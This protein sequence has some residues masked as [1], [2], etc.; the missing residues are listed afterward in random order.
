MVAFYAIKNHLF[1]NISRTVW[2]ILLIFHQNVSNDKRNKYI[3][4]FSNRLGYKG[5]IHA[6]A[7][8]KIDKWT[9]QTYRFSYF[10]QNLF[11]WFFL[12]FCMRWKVMVGHKMGL[13]AISRKF[14][15]FHND[16]IL[17]AK[18]AFLSISQGQFAR[19][20]SFFIKIRQIINEISTYIN[21]CTDSAIK[22]AFML[23][24]VQK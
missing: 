14:L 7:C 19:F 15:F 22:E 13:V 23:W 3:Y 1:V 2:P 21:F 5:G 8:P 20:C 12:I 6:W 4:Q 10:S 11:I 24:R 9:V 16:G 18:I 17:C